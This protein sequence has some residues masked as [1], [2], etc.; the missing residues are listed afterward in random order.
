MEWLSFG[1]I[2]FVFIFI[3]I[4][5]LLKERSLDRKKI[6]QLSSF[7]IGPSLVIYYFIGSPNSSIYSDIESE[8]DRTIINL[9][10]EIKTNSNDELIWISLAEAYSLK[11]Q[12]EKAFLSYEK[13]IG[14][15]NYSNSNTFANYG[16]A[17]IRAG[18]V[19]LLSQAND[20]FDRSLKLEPNNTK[21]LFLGGLTSSSIGDYDLAINRWELLLDLM[22]PE[23]TR[24]TLK[25]QLEEW[26]LIVSNNNISMIKQFYINVDVDPL[27]IDELKNYP[28]KQLFLII[29][30]PLNPIPPLAVT[31]E[32]VV[33]VS[34]YIGNADAMI[35]GI[36]LNQY[37][38]LEFVARISLSGD[39]L[40]RSND[41][42]DSVIIDISDDKVI[43]LQLTNN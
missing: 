36:D 19:T 22:P 25:E 23:E 33:S 40:D 38:Q 21:S 14:L 11:N 6:L 7:V 12:H 28:Q 43:S 29:R 10:E 32:N 42:S 26:N 8:I 37:D 1:L 5:P 30:D 31:R 39:P 35:K 18:D 34:K 16:E 2:I 41:I 9:E 13:A 3:L 17:M 20:L 4:L 24:D 27:L 15:E